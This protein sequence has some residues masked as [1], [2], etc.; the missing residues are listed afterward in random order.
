MFIDAD[1]KYIC[2]VR[3]GNAAANALQRGFWTHTVHAL[4]YFNSLTNGWISYA[5]NHTLVQL[6][7]LALN[8]NEDG[9]KTV[10]VILQENINKLFTNHE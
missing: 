2:E 10:N 8:A 3:Y 1:G 9:H 5:H 6:F 4:P 7:K